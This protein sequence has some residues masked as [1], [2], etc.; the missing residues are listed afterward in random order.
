MKCLEQRL[1]IVHDIFSIYSQHTVQRVA[2]EGK[3]QASIRAQHA[4]KQCPRRV[5][6]D[7]VDE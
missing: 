3:L 4:T 1:R 6:G 7:R 2:Y 5:L